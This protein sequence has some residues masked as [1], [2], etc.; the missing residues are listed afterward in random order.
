MID[1]SCKEHNVPHTCL[2]HY[3]NENSTVNTKRVFLGGLFKQSSELLPL[4]AIA[5][6]LDFTR[7]FPVAVVDKDLFI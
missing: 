1:A 3:I 6:S 7:I 2:V 5:T 4:H